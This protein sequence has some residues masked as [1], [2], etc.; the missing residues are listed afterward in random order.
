[1]EANSHLGYLKQWAVVWNYDD[2]PGE[3]LEKAYKEAI[4]MAAAI[5]KLMNLRGI[6]I[7]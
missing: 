4:N 6:K 2:V 5:E 3:Y 7:G 1:M